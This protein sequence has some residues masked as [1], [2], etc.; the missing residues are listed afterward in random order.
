[1]IQSNAW[2]SIE[3]F[4]L[5]FYEGA[6]KTE[7]FELPAKASARFALMRKVLLGECDAH[8]EGL[9]PAQGF[10][11]SL[12]NPK[13]SQLLAVVVKL[14]GDAAPIASEI[15]SE[16]APVPGSFASALPVGVD[17]GIDQT[18][19]QELGP[20]DVFDVDAAE[21]ERIE[22]TAEQE[23]DA[24][25]HGVSH[26]ETVEGDV[27]LFETARAVKGPIQK[28]K[29]RLW[30]VESGQHVERHDKFTNANPLLSSR[31]GAV[32]PCSKE[33]VATWI[34]VLSHFIPLEKEI[35]Q[36]VVW[37]SSNGTSTNDK[38]FQLL[39]KKVGLSESVE[40]LLIPREDD[41]MARKAYHPGE[42]PS[43]Q[44]RMRLGALQDLAV[45]KVQVC[46]VE[47][48]DLPAPQLMWLPSS[49][50]L[51]SKSWKPCLYLVLSFIY[52]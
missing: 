39:Q 35:T 26:T 31:C 19:E 34:G 29:T 3:D 28:D 37:R 30:L 23:L 25:F 4:K 14:W 17:P 13:V 18:A 15:E 7:I 9:D 45:D 32:P 50:W 27:Q 49:G 12:R 11:R 42:G 5:R 21:S 48:L 46:S 41:I 22:R 16:A 24:Y 44:E 6:D 52:V 40:W 51:D 10:E 36:N 20:L 1:V 38:S 8:F 2:K 43:L 33:Q 47:K